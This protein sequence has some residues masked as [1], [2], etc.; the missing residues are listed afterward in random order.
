MLQFTMKVKRPIWNMKT[1]HLPKGYD[2]VPGYDYF[3]G[4]MVLYPGGKLGMNV[5]SYNSKV[6]VTHT[7]QLSLSTS[8]CIV[9]DCIVE[10][11]GT[12]VTS[13]AVCSSIILKS[14]KE[15]KYVVMTLER[16]V[17]QRALHFVRFV[18]LAEKT[19]QLDIR[20]A[21][22]LSSFHLCLTNHEGIYLRKCETKIGK[23]CNPTSKTERGEAIVN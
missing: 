16:A 23:F 11:S 7:D 3:L 1:D 18:L 4:L 2:V 15:K 14:L 5:K 20:Y 17:S 21:H 19:K 9:G 12:P 10:V 8:T 13:T 6:Y 22:I